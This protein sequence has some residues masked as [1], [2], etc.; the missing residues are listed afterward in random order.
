MENPMPYT[1]LQLIHEAIRLARQSI[2]S[3][4][5]PFGAVIAKD[6]EIVASARNQ[7][8]QSHDPT[9]HAEI[10]A[11]RE[12]SSKLGRRHLTDCVLYSSSEPCPMCLGACYWAKIPEVFYGAS[13]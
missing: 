9:A 1:E 2:E 13:V 4:G 10:L 5:S 8:L 6:G 11:I 3:G 7:A 12:A